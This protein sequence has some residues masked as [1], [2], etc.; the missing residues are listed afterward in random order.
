MESVSK[1]PYIIITVILFI[2]FIVTFIVIWIMKN[3]ETYLFKPYEPPDEKY[4]FYPITKAYEPLTKDQ[5]ALRDKLL[6]E[7]LVDVQLAIELKKPPVPPN[8]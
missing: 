1:T 2:F 4:W 7:A 5:A 8:P 3:N 6:A